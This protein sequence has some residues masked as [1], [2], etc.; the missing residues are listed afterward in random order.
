MCRYEDWKC[1]ECCQGDR[2]NYYVTVSVKIFLYRVLKAYSP[3]H[4]PGCCSWAGAACRAA[5]RWWWRPWQPASS[6]PASGCR[7][8]GRAHHD[9]FIFIIK[10]NI[11]IAL[12]LYNF[13]SIQISLWS[14]K[15]RGLAAPPRP[16]ARRTPP[17]WRTGPP[18]SWR[19]AGR[20]PPPTLE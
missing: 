3:H 14:A 20:R 8:L 19:P 17:P 12:F 11:Y 4:D 13:V 18:G 9:L 15:S 7:D 2:C 5:A 1:A 10:T 16:P 6:S